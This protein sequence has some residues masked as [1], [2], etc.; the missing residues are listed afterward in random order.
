MSHSPPNT[1]P[2]TCDDV[3][4]HERVGCGWSDINQQQ[5]EDINCCFRNGICFFGSGATLHCTAEAEIILVVSRDVTLPNIDLQATSLLGAG[6]SCKPEIS[7][8]FCVFHFGVTECG[9]IAREEAGVLV[10]SNKVSS[11]YNVLTGPGGSI[12]RD[13]NFEV[14]IECRYYGSSKEAVI[15]QPLV[16]PAPASFVALGPMDVELRLGNGECVNKGCQE[17]EVAYYSYYSTSDYPVRK[18]L[19]DPVYVEVRLLDRTDPDLHLQLHNCWVTT[20]SNPREG[21]RWDLLIDGCPNSQDTYL[22]RMIR[23]DPEQVTFPS[24]YKRFVFNMFTFVNRA[25]S[26]PGGGS[27]KAGSQAAFDDV[28][29]F[30]DPIRENVYIHCDCT[31]CLS[32]SPNG[33]EQPCARKKRAIAS[34]KKEFRE[35]HVVVTSSHIV[36][37]SE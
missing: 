15:F 18:V 12:T 31:A 13:T 11:S 32:S 37:S 16:L 36:Y 6:D 3:E 8:A 24:H 29:E 9:T 23:V 26:S 34:A 25:L 35:N 21:P 2:S 5:C 17:D 20:S 28:V 4:P 14:D 19:R 27:K 30:V 7:A 22:T 33:C 1:P 10:Y